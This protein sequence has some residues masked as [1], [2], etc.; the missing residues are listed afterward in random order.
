MES[1]TICVPISITLLKGLSEA[2]SKQSKVFS[3]SVYHLFSFILYFSR[4]LFRLSRSLFLLSACSLMF[5]LKKFTTCWKARYIKAQD[6]VTWVAETSSYSNRLCFWAKFRKK[7]CSLHIA[8]TWSSSFLLQSLNY[9]EILFLISLD[10]IY[11]KLNDWFSY[12]HTADLQKKLENENCAHGNLLNLNGL[13][14][15]WSMVIAKS[16]KITQ[17]VKNDVVSEIKH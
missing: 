4:I 13:M 1:D 2:S 3:G 6:W 11:R 7:K 9:V 10:I 8:Y 17:C 16:I 15:L 12:V 5:A 14:T